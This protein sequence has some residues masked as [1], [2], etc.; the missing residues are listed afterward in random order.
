MSETRAACC[1]LWVTIT[2]E[3]SC[4]SS[5]IRSSILPV[6]IGSSAEQGSSIRI[7][8]GSTARQRAMQSRCCCPPDMPKAFA[9]EAVLDLVPERRAAQGALDHLVDV[10][11]M[12]EDARAEGDVVVDR[13]R[14]RV[15]L[16]EDHA[17]PLADLDR[18]DVGP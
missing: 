15:R 11:L 2:I 4:L 10:V 9:V 17:D 3:Y 12:P 5:I 16:L 6:E 8:S 13:L 14:E 7:T 1:M 18:V